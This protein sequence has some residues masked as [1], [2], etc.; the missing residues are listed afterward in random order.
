MGFGGWRVDGSSPKMS[1]SG[2]DGVCMRSNLEIL[3]DIIWHHSAVPRCR[4]G[5]WFGM[6]LFIYEIER[7][8]ASSISS[9]LVCYPRGSSAASHRIGFCRTEALSLSNKY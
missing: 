2:V 8:K 7:T 5:G 4:F 9:E 3:V 1:F 6:V